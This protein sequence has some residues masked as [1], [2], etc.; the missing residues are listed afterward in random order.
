MLAHEPKPSR[1]QLLHTVIFHTL[2]LDAQCRQLTSAQST[3]NGI[4][5][6]WSANPGTLV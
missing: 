3:W 6:S 1:L 4:L 5:L 2:S